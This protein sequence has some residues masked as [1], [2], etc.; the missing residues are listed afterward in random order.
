MP[1]QERR[2]DRGARVAV[3]LHRKLGQDLRALRRQAGLSQRWLAE[4]VGVQH[5]VISR[6]EAG[7]GMVTTLDLYARLF[8]VLGGRLSVK[9][10]PEADPLRDEAHLR[11][12]ERLIK[13]LH[14][15]IR[16]R[17]EVP[18]GIPGDLRAW[19]LM[20]MAGARHAAVEA[21]MVLDDL[22]ALE[23]KIALKQQDGRIEVVILLIADTKRNR[24][25]LATHRE[26]LRERFPLDTRA[27][28]AH[29]RAGRIPP[30]SAIVIL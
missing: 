6:I 1:V 4:Q 18:L 29:L 26:V 13:L 11:L 21:E 5:S 7:R 15:A 23:R 25:I 17:R 27:A 28:L 14:A 9:V 22:Q 24:R 2:T 8:A 10:Y 20:L 16:A 3:I 19:D 12:I 30:E